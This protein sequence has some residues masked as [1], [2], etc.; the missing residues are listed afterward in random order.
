MD[1]F[2]LSCFKRKDFSYYEKNFIQEI[3]RAEDGY[4]NL[5]YK[6]SDIFFLI[7]KRIYRVILVHAS[8]TL[9]KKLMT[10]RIRGDPSFNSITYEHGF[11]IID[12]S[13]N[14][15]PVIII[16]NNV[17]AWEE[18]IKNYSLI[19]YQTIKRKDD[20]IYKK[21]L[22]TDNFYLPC[23]K[24]LKFSKIYISYEQYMHCKNDIEFNTYKLYIYMENINNLKNLNIKPTQF[25][26]IHD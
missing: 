23:L 6:V 7:K 26:V 18:L 19:T 8:L 21:F 13:I 22:L 24:Y 16:V 15:L 2:Y 1:P 12:I 3:I 11:P 25:Y 4:W 20:L 9:Y 5:N 17:S 14:E 10:E